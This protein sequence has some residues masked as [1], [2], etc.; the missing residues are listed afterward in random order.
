[1]NDLERL[2]RDH[3]SAPGHG[4]G[5]HD[6]LWAN[7]AADSASPASGAM[8]RERASAE[9]SPSRRIR[10]RYVAL[11][12]AALAAVALVVGTS[13]TR[14]AVQEYR[15]PG[16]ASAAEVAANVRRSLSEIRTLRADSTESFRVVKGPPRSEWQKGWTTADWWA[17]ARIYG[18]ADLKALQA[19]GYENPSMT[20]PTTKIVATA[21]GRWR[22]DSP[23]D[24][25]S[26]PPVIVDQSAG[27]DA[28]GVVKI[29]WP[30]DALHV[31]TDVPLG[32]PDDM[33]GAF[34][35]GIDLSV[36]FIRPAT[37]AAM[38]H[39][40]VSEI[41]LDG[42]PCL[43]VSCPIAPMPIKG[44]NMDSHLFDTV[45]YTVDR[46]TWL[47]VRMRMLLRGQM[48]W[49][50]RL[51]HVRVNA[52]VSDAELEPSYPRDTKV[53]EKSLRFRR[54]PLG[55]AGHVFATRPLEPRDV[56]S[57]FRLYAA[58]ASRWMKF[59]LWTYT[60]GYQPPYWPP[61][62]DVTQLG[63]RAGLLQFVVTTR[64]QPSGG[65]LPPDPFAADPFVRETAGDD[66]AHTGELEE[67]KL[68]GGAWEG[69]TAY[70]VTPL[71]DSP[72]LWAWHDGVLVTVGGDLT[73]DQLLAVAD[74]LEPMK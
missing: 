31:G 54:V 6:R 52:P 2:L 35:S 18:E 57:E 62:R 40:R 16:I 26:N 63:Y 61:S 39:G 24:Y 1:M 17:R 15:H 27:N 23:E 37:L 7:V 56:P 11:L 74:S 36:R 5:F 69:V 47:I 38:A 14:D 48:V 45:E 51:T 70:V 65:P 8:A 42:R 13:L 59:S 58:A 22:K 67:V 68:S 55:E 66:V 3:G 46:E 12:A 9:H 20:F 53:K 21:D 4:P 44:L 50:S 49:E 60:D 29:Y 73:R 10:G 28:T 41:T 33:Q 30:G 19:Q 34:S 25:P 64:A 43:T 32:A 71:L 72:H